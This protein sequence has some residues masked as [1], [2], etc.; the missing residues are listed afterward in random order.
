MIAVAQMTGRLLRRGVAGFVALILGVALFEFIQPAVADSFG[1]ADRMASIFAS[2]PPTLQALTRAQPEFLFMSGLAGYLSLGFTHPVFHVLLAAAIVGFTSR[3]LAGE[4]ERGT[5]QI[6]LAR[7]ISRTQVYLARVAGVIAMSLALAAA[8][9]LGM[10]LGL[11]LIQPDG[12][13]AHGHFVPVAI[14]TASLI[15]AIGGLTLFG[16]ALAST[17]GRAVAWATAGLLLSYFVDY[18]AAIW[19]FLTP[20]EPLSI[21]HYFDPSPLLVNGRFDLSNA[22]ILVGIGL[23]GAIAGLVVFVRRDL[24]T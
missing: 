19:R 3:T 2:L 14:A 13:V 10:I 17:A 16:S 6:A 9:P 15:W 12:D 7:P 23:A 24:P 18:F 20:L 4:M 1:G 11:V 5:I 21:F 22:A 8:G